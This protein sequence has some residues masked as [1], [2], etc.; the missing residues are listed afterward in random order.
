MKKSQHNSG[1]SLFLMEMILALL[2]L[3]LSCAACVQIFGSAHKDQV[4]TEQ[5]EHIQAL[6]TSVGEALEGTDGSFREL[7]SL[8]PDGINENTELIWYYD[9]SWQNC[10]K[11]EASYEMVFV[12]DG[13][14]SKAAEKSGTLS[15]RQ[16]SDQTEL[17]QISFLFPVCSIS[18]EA[19]K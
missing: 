13:K 6:T 15:F 2:F 19:N 18:K 14:S 12:P 16:I 10:S 7:L 1:N 3:S 17:Y 11:K 4:R 8:L 9:H 5:L